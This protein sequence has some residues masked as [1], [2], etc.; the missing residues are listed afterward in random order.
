MGTR[1]IN[2]K[3]FSITPGSRYRDEGKKS[4]SGQEFRED[5]LE[6][7]FKEIIETDEK[8]IVNLDGTIGYGTSWLEEVFG[9]LARIY[10]KKTVSEKIIFI[11][12]E[13][14]Y[15]IEDLNEYIK[16]A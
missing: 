2:V 8:L 9:G 13:E 7:L 4:H 16:D 6:P 15:L 10:G 3:D 5:Y 11:S 1:I 12:D 14:P